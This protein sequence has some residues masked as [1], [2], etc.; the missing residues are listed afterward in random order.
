Y[1]EPRSGGRSEG[2]SGHR[3]ATARVARADAHATV[4]GVI[5]RTAVNSAPRKLMPSENAVLSP[6]RLDGLMAEP[7]AI[8]LGVGDRVVY[9]NQ[10][11]C[12]VTGV[13]SKEI[14]GQKLSF[15]SLLR[16]EDGA[17]V[18]VPE[19]KVVSIGV[20]K[21]SSGD[22]VEKVLAFLK[23]DSDKASLD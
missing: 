4:W 17:R 1:D 8:R 16:E 7:A 14:A 15:V 22:E 23:S 20:R 5:N 21:V 10:G 19:A 18:M 2:S 6:A 13:E 12:K 3:W 9:P 11:L